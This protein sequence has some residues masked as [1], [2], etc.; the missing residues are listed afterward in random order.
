MPYLTPE[1][2]DTHL[3]EE[4]LNEIV[5]DDESLIEK[6]IAAA[7]SEAKSYFGRFDLEKLFTIV[8]DENLK[9][10]VKDIALWRLLRL[11]NPNIS[12]ELA[13]TNYQDTI[14]VFV[15]IQEG[16]VTP[17]NW[18]LKADLTP[19]EESGN[20]GWSSNMKRRNHY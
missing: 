9:N 17:D 15:K 18:P 12:M 3:Y 1:E 19:L 11:A 14:K 2:L 16:K 20:I 5:R 7:V 13:R 6:A 4:Q 10:Q 8:D